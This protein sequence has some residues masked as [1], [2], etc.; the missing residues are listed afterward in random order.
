[1]Q[2]ELSTGL[3]V[4]CGGACAGLVLRE[5]LGIFL[6]WGLYS[7]PACTNEWYSRNMYIK[8]MP[9]YEHHRKTYGEQREFGYKDF[10]PLFCAERFD[11]ASWMQLFKAGAGYVFPVAEHHDGFQMYESELSHW[12]AKE[13]GPKRSS[14]GIKVGSRVLRAAVLHFK[15]QGGTLVF[16]GHGREFDSDVREPMKK[17]DFYWPAMPEPDPQ[18]LSANPSRARNFWTTGW[19]ARWS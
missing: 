9:A 1:M 18:D 13:M 12:N 15:P 3:G 5:K 7:V 2:R 11:P 10:I 4:A 17:G 16:M 8:G 6:H 19:R 14:R